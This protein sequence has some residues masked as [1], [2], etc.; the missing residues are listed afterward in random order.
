FVGAALV[1]SVTIQRLLDALQR[2]HH[3]QQVI[4][5][6]YEMRGALM[7]MVAVKRAYHLLGDQQF[8]RDYERARNNFLSEMTELQQ[9]TQEVPEQQ[10]ILEKIQRSEQQ[11]RR[12]AEQDFATFLASGDN[13]KD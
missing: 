4:A 9:L 10:Q 13:E 7:A 11:W 1:S 3:S 8:R 12:I 5:K 6:A 2:E